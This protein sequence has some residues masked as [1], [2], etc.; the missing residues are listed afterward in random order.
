MPHAKVGQP[1]TDIIT[2]DW[3]NNLAKIRRHLNR[4]AAYTQ[5]ANPFVAPCI[6]NTDQEIDAHKPVKIDG[7]WMEYEDWDETDIRLS[8]V[9]VKVDETVVSE[10]NWGVLKSYCDQESSGKVVL[11]GLVWAEVEQVDEDHEYVDIIDGVI[12]TTSTGTS[13]LISSPPEGEG[14]TGLCLVFLERGGSV[15]VGALKI[16]VVQTPPDGQVNSGRVGADVGRIWLKDTVVNVSIVETGDVFSAINV[17]RDTISEG[18][19]V[20]YQDGDNPLI[21]TAFC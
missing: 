20:I 14:T 7:A 13:L 21:I 19:Y 16:G 15:S 17:S 18:D 12:K 4:P 11:R 9:G 3:V 2:T 10:D 5:E 1:L 8:S 6:A